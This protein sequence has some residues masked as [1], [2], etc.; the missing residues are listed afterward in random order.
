MLKADKLCVSFDKKRILTD[1]SLTCGDRG[2]V[3]VMGVSGIG[4]TTLLRVLAGLMKPNSGTVFSD[5]SKISFKFQ[6]PRLFEWLTSRENIA[7]VLP[8]VK[9]AGELADEWLGKVG[10]ADA[11]DRF[12]AELS[13]GMRQ[14]VALARALAYD[15]DLLLLDEPFS[16]VDAGT[17]ERLLSLVRNY[18]VDHAVILVTHSADEAKALDAVVFHMKHSTDTQEESH[19]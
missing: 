15:G 9:N 17:K 11:A 5:F 12:P 16:A 2:I 4:K 10:L 18:A 1:F 19:D 14:R 13:G 6:E 7:A 8:N 3:A